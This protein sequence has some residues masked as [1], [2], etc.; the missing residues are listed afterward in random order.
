MW[1]TQSKLSAV[2]STLVGHT[3]G[4]YALAFSPGGR[5]LYSGASDSYDSSTIRMTHPLAGGAATPD[6]TMKKKKKRLF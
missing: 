6:V 4:V 5:A 2:H 1:D 3:G